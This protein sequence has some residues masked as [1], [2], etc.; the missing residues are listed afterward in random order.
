MLSLGMAAD[1]EPGT[2]GHQSNATTEGQK[3]ESTGDI[4]SDHF[5]ESSHN[6]GHHDDVGEVVLEAFQ[7]VDGQK[8]VVLLHFTVMPWIEIRN[9]ELIDS[10]TEDQQ[11][12][13]DHEI[14]NTANHLS[15]GV[16]GEVVL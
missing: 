15:N 8:I 1:D 16:G 9:H 14:I 13:A 11:S 10:I 2:D 6:Q 5:L 7:A 12:N 4:E 3:I